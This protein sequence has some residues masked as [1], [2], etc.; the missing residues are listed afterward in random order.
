MAAI[1]EMKNVGCK[2]GHSYLLKNIN[3][4]IEAGEHWVVFGTNGS[5]KTTL[6]SILAG[7]QKH[8]HGSLKVFGEPYSA[9][10]VLV[11]RK[12]IGWVSSSFFDKCFRYEQVLAIVLSGL[13]GTLNIDASITD[14]DVLRAQ[15][16][17]DQ[18]GI[19]HKQ[20]MLYSFLSKGERQH[21]ILARALISQP[22]LLILDEPGSGL[23][24]LAREKMLDMVQRT[25]TTTNTTIIYVTHYLEEV[26]ASFDQCLLLK[27]GRIYKKGKSE[28][29]FSQDVL[30]DF[31][32]QPLTLKKDNDH[33]MYIRL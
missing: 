29:I 33:H 17:L 1:V 25:A 20:D 32:D 9:D 10:N 22:E 26:L 2:S 15:A 7:F 11:N 27:H 21:V 12:R 6:L 31:L 5:G 19:L 3:W 30:S 16:L 24:V 28:E 14:K 13:T 18:F 8:T 23:D 4:K